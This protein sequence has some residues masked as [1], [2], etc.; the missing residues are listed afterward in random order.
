M[1]RKG[2]QM[3]RLIVKIG[4]HEFSANGSTPDA[5][6]KDYKAWLNAI[7]EMDE[8]TKPKQQEGDNGGQE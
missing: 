1:Y 5:T 8:S 4:P 2:R 7:K 3:Y 6:R